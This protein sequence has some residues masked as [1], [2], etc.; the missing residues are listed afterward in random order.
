MVYTHLCL[1]S[2]VQQNVS[3]VYS[4]Y[5]VLTYLEAEMPG[6]KVGMCLALIDTNY[7]FPKFTVPSLAPAISPT[8]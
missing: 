2:R 8:L 7:S 6:P 3:E 1:V 4:C 5:C